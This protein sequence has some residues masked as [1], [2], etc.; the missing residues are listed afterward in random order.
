MKV[1]LG[2]LSLGTGHSDPADKIFIGS[3]YSQEYF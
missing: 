1:L 3:V 2:L